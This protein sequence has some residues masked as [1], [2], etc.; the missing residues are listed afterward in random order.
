MPIIKD[1]PNGQTHHAMC[2]KEHKE[3]A[4]SEIVVY[5]WRP[6]KHDSW[7]V[8]ED[9]TVFVEDIGSMLPGDTYEIRCR[10][11]TR[12]AY[13]SMKEHDGW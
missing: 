11:M 7:C 13:H 10:K 12:L 5:L 6:T 2:W 9:L 4:E 3:C 8:M 1:T